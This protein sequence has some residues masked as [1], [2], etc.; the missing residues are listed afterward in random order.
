M[1][2]SATYAWGCTTE[3]R[4]LRQVEEA[5]LLPRLDMYYFR[6]PRRLEAWGTARFHLSLRLRA[7]A[8]RVRRTLTMVPR[9]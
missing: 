7:H 6:A 1:A 8:R 4:A 2:V 3:L 5:A 9:S